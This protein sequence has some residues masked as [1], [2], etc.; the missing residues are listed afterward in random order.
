MPTL[1]YHILHKK[2]YVDTKAKE[3]KVYTQLSTTKISYKFNFTNNCVQPLF[4]LEQKKIKKL[5]KGF[6]QKA[7]SFKH[8][9]PGGIMQIQNETFYTVRPARVQMHAL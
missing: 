5:Q 1:S 2:F 8:L 3:R 4:Y 6:V 9:S 7:T